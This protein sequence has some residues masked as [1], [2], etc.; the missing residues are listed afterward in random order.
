VS[1]AAGA[2]WNPRPPTSKQISGQNGIPKIGAK[3]DRPTP[4][5]AES[6][7]A[8]RCAVGGNTAG[9]RSC[10]VRAS[11]LHRTCITRAY[12]FQ[13]RGKRVSSSWTK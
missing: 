9:R 2:A 12:L 10:I 4:R 5:T 8:I 7:Y 13:Q 3:P 6:A 11:L 1:W